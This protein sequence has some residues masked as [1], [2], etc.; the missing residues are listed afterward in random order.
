MEVKP[1]ESRIVETGIGELMWEGWAGFAEDCA[2]TLL[3]ADDH[4]KFLNIPSAYFQGSAAE[5]S[6]FA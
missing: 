4:K 3:A 5:G 6:R 1:E 2:I